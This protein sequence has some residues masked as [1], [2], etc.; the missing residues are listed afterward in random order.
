M[1]VKTLQEIAEE[2]QSQK[3]ESAGHIYHPLPFPEFQHL[4]TSSNP[5]SAYSKWNL[6]SHSLRSLPPYTDLTALDVGANAGFYSFNLAK[7]GVKVDAYEPH[8]H[9]VNVGRQIVETT[10]LPV[11]WYN[12]PLEQEDIAKKYDIAVMLSVFQW[13]SHGNEQLEEATEI[14]HKV[15]LA[16]RYLFFEL[17]CNQGKSAIHTEERPLGWIWRLLEQTTAPKHIFFLGTTTAWGRAKRY[18]FACA[19]TPIHLT[20][21][22]RLVTHLLYNRWI[23]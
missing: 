1:P 2:V 15:A 21:R 8:E 6:I 13:M 10:G 22:Q 3:Q 9:Y 23:G 12:K 11:Q 4:K 18:L 5:K 19:D 17:G 14:L 16:S 7:L 20:L